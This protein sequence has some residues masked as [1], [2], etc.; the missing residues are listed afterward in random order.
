MS[1]LS[2]QILRKLIVTHN[3]APEQLET[4]TQREQRS[5]S[6]FSL[7]IISIFGGGSLSMIPL[8]YFTGQFGLLGVIP[9][10]MICVG[11]S[12]FVNWASHYPNLVRFGSWLMLGCTTL[13]MSFYL[14]FFG[15]N[16]PMAGLFFLP[17]VMSLFLLPWY[18]T[19]LITM[20]GLAVTSLITLLE[21][22]ALLPLS[23]ITA[24]ILTVIIW[25]FVLIAP[26]ALGLYLLSQLNTSYKQ[27]TTQNNRISEA[28][29]SVERKR[30][31]GQMVSTRIQSVSAEL[32]ATASQQASGSQQQVAAIQEITAFLQELSQTANEITHKAENINNTST[33]VLVTAQQVI[34]TADLVKERG[35]EGLLA[36]NSTIAGNHRITALYQKMVEILERLENRSSQIN[37]INQLIKDVSDEMHLLALN[38]TLEAAGA[39]EY[40]ERF[41]VVAREVKSLSNRSVKASKE[42]STILGEVGGEIKIAVGAAGE[43]QRETIAALG[44]AVKSGEVMNEL[45]IAIE[46]NAKV[47]N[48]IED[49]TNLMNNFTSEIVYATSQQYSGSKQ[50]VDSLQEIGTIARQ[51]ATGSIQVIT[52]AREMEEFSRE[53]AETLAVT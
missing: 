12:I 4:K 20:T 39:G 9:P 10:T 7:I 13:S 40:G 34:H 45:L 51:S 21:F 3:L 15:P 16:Q 37:Q 33:D 52:T 25:F 5:L 27:A 50:A 32:H 36:V 49:S 8:S 22:Q 11:V 18:G 35:E 24:T 53:L 17:I 46:Q 19:L 1:L 31:M 38:A 28:F 47:G 41:G 14:I 42:V 29:R 30:E 48:W 44:L 26:T 6:V 23:G 2:P 43:C